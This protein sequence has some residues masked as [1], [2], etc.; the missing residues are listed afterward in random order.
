[1]AHFLRYLTF[2]QV[3]YF[4][5]YHPSTC[6]CAMPSC[7]LSQ[8]WF[9]FS[10]WQPCVLADRRFESCFERR[11]DLRFPK[12]QCQRSPSIEAVNFQ[13][14]ALLSSWQ[15][16]PRVCQLLSRRK[17]AAEIQPESSFL[18]FS[19]RDQN[20]RFRALVDPGEDICENDH[21]TTVWLQKETQWFAVCTRWTTLGCALSGGPCG[22]EQG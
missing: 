16:A 18:P 4:S 3:S 9:I 5:G 12:S 2:L 6:C 19:S 1:M 15:H 11:A 20:L 22:T 10:Q 13:P 21:V 8:A 14:R 7:S 17:Q